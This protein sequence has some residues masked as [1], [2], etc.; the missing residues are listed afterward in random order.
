MLFNSIHFL[1][2]FPVILLLYFSIKHKYR[3][4]LLLVGSY[5][6]YMSWRAEYIILIIVSTLIDYIAGSQ[7]YKSKTK[8]RKKAFL[9]ISLLVNLGLLFAF[10]YFN[11]F[12]DTIRTVIS[13][14]TIPLNPVTLNVLLPVGI[15]GIDLDSGLQLRQ[16]FFPMARFIK[17]VSS[18]GTVF[19]VE[20][21]RHGFSPS[22]PQ[23]TGA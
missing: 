5:Y 21:L 3:W 8:T 20:P 12:S 10:K 15:V 22:F 17:F 6:F 7:I 18:L 11:F 9:S 2:F 19:C 14:Y 16:A 1:I 13:H 4:I 23:V